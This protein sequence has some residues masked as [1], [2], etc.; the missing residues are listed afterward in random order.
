MCRPANRSSTLPIPT[1]GIPAAAS[2]SSSVVPTGSIEK[3]R[4]FGVRAY[5]PG[6]PTNDHAIT[7][8]TACSPTSSS[9]A[10]RQAPYSSSNGTD[11]AC[12]AGPEP[13]RG[14]GDGPAAPEAEAL[15]VR[16]PQPA[17]G[18]GHVAERVAAAVAVGD[19][20]RGGADAHAVK[21]DDR[22]ALQS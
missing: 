17:D 14:P 10:V 8:L 9:R 15:Q 16:E 1:R 6:R 18:A 12:G 5:A 4:R 7:R 13:G 21:H 19:G 22:C 20:V 2:W 3:S 11:A